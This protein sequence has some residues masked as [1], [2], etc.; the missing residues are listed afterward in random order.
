MRSVGLFV[1]YTRA[2]ELLV[3]TVREDLERLGHSVW[4]DHQIHGGES[5]WRE[6]VQEI[7]RTEVFVFALSDHSQRSKPCQLELRYADQLGIPVLPL[8]VGPLQSMFIP[9][10]E[11]QMIDYRERTADA[12]IQLV[13]AIKELTAQPVLLPDP[14]P[15][16]PEVPFEYLFRIARV[17]GPERITPDDQDNLIWQLRSKLKEED[18]EVAKADIVKLL[19]ELRSRGEL[20]QQNARE[21]DEV[22][23]RS[24]AQA[25]E[26]PTD[27]ATR[28]PPTEH[29]RGGERPEPALSQPKREGL[30]STPTPAADSGHG[31]GVRAGGSTTVEPPRPAP[32]RQSPES[33]QSPAASAQPEPRQSRQSP[34]A[35]GWRS[36]SAASAAPGQSRQSAVAPGQSPAAAQSGPERSRQSPSQPGPQPGAAG[37]SG[38]AASRHASPE[39]GRQP[40]SAAS[41]QSG[42]AQQG[43]AQPGPG[44]ARHAP[45]EREQATGSQPPG[46]GGTGSATAPAWLADIVRNSE[47]TGRQKATGSRETGRSA[48]DSPDPRRAAGSPAALGWWDSPSGQA[49]PGA[50]PARGATARTG[51]VLGALG[52]PFLV[53]ALAARDTLANPALAVFV[54]VATILGLVLAVVGARRR[55]PAYRPAVVVAA[56]GLL[57]A[58]AYAIAAWTGS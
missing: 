52:I 25:V 14:L 56:V 15:V 11:R 36:H 17:M 21:I 42:P 24:V 4:M 31:T 51:L 44:V 10:A 35:P 48:D 6:I 9:L 54:L 23:T 55:E 3:R 26:V 57:S 16:P 38:A 1:S 50:H 30:Q 46:P 40:H 41:A 22:L 12:V 39:S 13:I 32:T 43:P 58:I 45:P 47:Q 29:W 37:Q 19:K 20:T 34:V 7:Q 8:R 27:G 18:D 49:A 5:W 53:L 2:D 28:L 33:G